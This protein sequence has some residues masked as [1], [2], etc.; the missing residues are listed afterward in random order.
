MRRWTG[1]GG[2]GIKELRE[3]SRA[4][5]KIHTECEP[6]TEQ[7]KLIVSGAPEQTQ[8]ALSLIQQRLAMGP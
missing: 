2:A 8:Y 4:T 3:L 5:I 1:R 7:R 6:G